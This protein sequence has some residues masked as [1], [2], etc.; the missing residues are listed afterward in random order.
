MIRRIV[1]EQRRYR[2]QHNI[3]GPRHPL[4]PWVLLLPL[5]FMIFA[6]F[7]MFVALRT[8]A[9]EPM[10]C[11]Q[12][13][14][15]YPCSPAGVIIAVLTT[16]PEY[17][18]AHMVFRTWGKVASDLG[19]AVIFFGEKEDP[20]LPVVV[21]K[22]G[23]AIAKSH[24]IWKWLHYHQYTT[25]MWYMKVY[26]TTFVHPFFLMKNMLC[27]KNPDENWYIGERGSS[28]HTKNIFFAGGNAGYILT[29]SS[30]TALLQAWET[31]ACPETVAEDVTVAMCM[32]NYL[33]I[34]LTGFEQFIPQFSHSYFR[35]W[36]EFITYGHVSGSLTKQIAEHAF[37]HCQY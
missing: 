7:L 29:S 24:A 33:Q 1:D 5:T 37:D 9:D 13:G 16:D 14:D 17:K 31:G 20:N 32:Q 10:P 26:D 34:P 4:E 15:I 19:M 18:Q 8:Q 35:P 23:T 27:G 21:I 28:F 6:I 30:L 12:P 22:P 36:S 25:G 11:I 3:T 2:K